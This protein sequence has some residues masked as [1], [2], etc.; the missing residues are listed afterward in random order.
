MYYKSLNRM[1]GWINS[2]K[3][4]RVCRVNLQIEL[5]EET[6]AFLLA[7]LLLPQDATYGDG[8]QLRWNDDDLREAA[9]RFTTFHGDP[10]Y[11]DWTDYSKD[12]FRAIL[13]DLR[14]KLEHGED[15]DNP[16]VT[17]SNP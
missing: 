9:R 5:D 3:T 17:R 13:F 1:F 12:A 14:D 7:W 2:L 16:P 11:A 15:R 8:C 10:H 4:S 6:A